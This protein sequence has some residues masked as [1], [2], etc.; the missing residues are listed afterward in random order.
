MA[1]SVLVPCLLALVV[2]LGGCTCS[3]KTDEEI[4][5]ERIDTTAVHLYLATKIAVLKADQSE[6][7]KA[8]RDNLLAAIEVLQGEQAGDAPELT[9]SDVLELAKALYKLKS[10]GEELLHSGDEKGMQPV[11]LALFEP[12]EELRDVFD[13]NLEHAALLLG[14]FALRFHPKSPV[15]VP[16]ELMLYEAW[17]TDSTAIKLGGIEGIVQ[18]AKAVVYGQNELCD[19]A[20]TEAALADASAKKAEELAVALSVVSN[21]EATMT[22]E[23]TKATGGGIRALAHGI[24][25]VCYRGRD[26]QEK[27]IESFDKALQAA[28]DMGVAKGELALARAYVAFERKEHA[29]ARKHLETARDYEGT[30]PETKKDV[31]AILENLEDDPN[32]F[33]EKLGKAFFMVNLTKIVLRQADKAGVFDEVKDAELVKTLDAFLSALAASIKKAEDTL[34]G[35]GLIDDAKKLVNDD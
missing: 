22:P 32:V 33:E 14:M 25:A 19:L 4:L 2:L 3:K 35:K 16:P 1:R 11:L 9:A 7:A 5:K 27:A 15:P 26:E 21:T 13:L 30:D 6:E 10:E 31:E 8:A 12:H 24:T 34:T 23:E 20:A 28:E 18:A 29:Q 17:M